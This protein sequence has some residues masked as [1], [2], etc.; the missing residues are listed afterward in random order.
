MVTGELV[1]LDAGIV[2]T[3]FDEELDDDAALVATELETAEV[4]VV[5]LAGKVGGVELESGALVV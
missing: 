3:E 5:E 2:A 1:E 4:G